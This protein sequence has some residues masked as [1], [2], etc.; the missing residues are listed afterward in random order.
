M[1]PGVVAISLAGG[2]NGSVANIS[3]ADFIRIMA[4]ESA[5]SSGICGQ[6]R[7]LL[8]WRCLV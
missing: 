2:S 5:Q 1:R 6:R 7:C 8:L 4:Q 3:A